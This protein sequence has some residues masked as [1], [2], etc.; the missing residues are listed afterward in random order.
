MKNLQ[1]KNLQ[2]YFE[3]TSS[4]NN[5]PDGIWQ[6]IGTVKSLQDRESHLCKHRLTKTLISSETHARVGRPLKY[7]TFLET[8]HTQ[9]PTEVQETY[10]VAEVLF[11]PLNVNDARDDN[12]QVIRF[13][14]KDDNPLSGGFSQLMGALTV[15]VST[16]CAPIPTEE[17]PKK[18]KRGR[19]AKSKPEK[20]EQK[21]A[22]AS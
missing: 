1:R 5:T 14:I 6:Y 16:L 13:Q 22:S 2:E 10:K 9:D 20:V 3:A 8:Y 11:F 19:P 18:K 7:Q 4:W 15:Q 21:T 12:M 17:V